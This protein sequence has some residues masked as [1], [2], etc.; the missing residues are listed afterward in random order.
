MGCIY[1]KEMTRRFRYS[2]LLLAALL[3]AGCEDDLVPPSFIHLDAITLVPPSEGAVTLD[4]GFYTSDIVAVYAVAHYAGA[5]TVDTLGLFRLPCDIAVLHDGPVEYLNLYPAVEQS[6]SSLALPF[7]TFYNRIRLENLTLTAGDTLNL[8]SLTTTYNPQNNVMLFEPFEPTEG[9]LLFDSVMQWRPVAPEEACTGMGYGYV[10][11][12][13]SVYALTFGI[14]RDFVVTDPSTLLYLEF[15]V[16]SDLPFR[17]YMLTSELRGANPTLYSVM[18]VRASEEWVHIY[19]NLGRTWA[20]VNHNPDFR[21]QFVAQNE[22]GVGGEVRL[23]NVRLMA[24][25]VAL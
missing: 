1:S 5:P 22:E 12:P 13:D 4:P 7:Y 24:T 9:S 14:D 25:T 3:A 11:V 2:L 15:D 19:A 10:P 18:E 6:G 16:R 23:D 17:V 8:G 21:I 20:Y